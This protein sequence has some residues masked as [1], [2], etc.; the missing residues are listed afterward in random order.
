MRKRCVLFGVTVGALGALAVLGLTS[1]APQE[2]VPEG[3]YCLK[4]GMTPTEVVTAFGK[5]FGDYRTGETVTD[6]TRPSTWWGAPERVVSA[7]GWHCDSY[8]ADVG[9]DASGRACYGQVT[10]MRKTSGNLFTNF[11][12]RAKRQWRR[13]FP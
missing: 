2:T 12:W 5:L 3:Y 9:F 13:W 6:G 11:F 10:P 8:D 7:G 1:N 4:E